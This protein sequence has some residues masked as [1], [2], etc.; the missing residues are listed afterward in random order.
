MACTSAYRQSHT[1]NNESPS[2]HLT[3]RPPNTL[4]TYTVYIHI[5]SSLTNTLQ[6]FYLLVVKIS[7]YFNFFFFPM[8][9]FVKVI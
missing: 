9:P 4:S 1:F 3:N 7:I 6:H 5:Y 8:T 2:D